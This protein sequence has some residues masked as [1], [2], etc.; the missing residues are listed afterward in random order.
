MVPG[1]SLRRFAIA[2]DIHIP[3]G[4]KWRPLTGIEHGGKVIFRLVEQVESPAADARGV[5]FNH[6]KGSCHRDGCIE[7]VASLSQ[8]AHSGLCRCRV[9]GCNSP[10]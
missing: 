7:G 6:G 5:G 4:G 1:G 10:G 9:R 2:A 8:N 3:A